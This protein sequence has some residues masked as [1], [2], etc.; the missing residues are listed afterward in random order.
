MAEEKSMIEVFERLVD[1]TKEQKELTGQQL[2]LT[3]KQKDI[4]DELGAIKDIVRQHIKSHKD[5]QDTLFQKRYSYN[6]KEQ[7]YNKG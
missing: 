1:L 2:E 6:K 7:T 5:M 3:K 4:S